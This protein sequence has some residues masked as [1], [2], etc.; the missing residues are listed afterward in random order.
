MSLLD[1]LPHTAS[2][3]PRVHTQGTHGGSRTSLGTALFT[4][5]ACWRQPVSDRE[6]VEYEKPGVVV[7]NKVYFVIDPAV[8]ERHVMV[9]DG[10]EF[11]VLSQAKPDATAGLEWAFR[12]MIGHK[13]GDQA[14]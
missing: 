3:Y 9:I 13:T 12:V 11:D 10:D 7:T 2:A 4:D 6:A 8:D 1:N 14:G 5:R